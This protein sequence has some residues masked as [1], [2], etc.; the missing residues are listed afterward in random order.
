MLQQTRAETVVSYYERFLAR[1]PDVYAL[2]G[3]PNV[4]VSRAAETPVWPG[5]E[6]NILSSLYISTSLP[7]EK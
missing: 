4:T 5:Y 2:A 3:S 1:Y 6:A 7:R